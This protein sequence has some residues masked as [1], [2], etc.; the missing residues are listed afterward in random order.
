[1]FYDVFTT[2]CPE[3][4]EQTQSASPFAR[5]PSEF[6]PSRSRSTEARCWK[7]VFEKVYEFSFLVS[8]SSLRRK[9]DYPL[10][11]VYDK[12]V[13]GWGSAKGFDYR[14]NKQGGSVFAQI[15]YVDLKNP[16]NE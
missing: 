1:M 3:I 16:K 5:F 4:Y 13:Q 6:S 9:F 14:M 15:F 11:V 7:K 2:H 12:R 10:L 8:L